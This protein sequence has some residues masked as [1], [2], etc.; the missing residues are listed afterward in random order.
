MVYDTAVCTGHGDQGGK[1]FVRC[2]VKYEVSEAFK[3][4]KTPVAKAS[5]MHVSVPLV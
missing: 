3:Q 5:M 4:I 1:N 2:F